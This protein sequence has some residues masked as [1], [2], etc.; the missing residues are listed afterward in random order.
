M[1]IESFETMRQRIPGCFGD[2]DKIFAGHPLDE[3]RAKELRTYCKENDID[4]ELVV[5]AAAGYIFRKGVRYMPHFEEQLTKVRAFF[6][7]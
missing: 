6:S 5:D 4:V 3:G 7:K 2:Q 1:T